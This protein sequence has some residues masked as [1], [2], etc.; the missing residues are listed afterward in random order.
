[1][2]I[3]AILC[4][5]LMFSIL[6]LHF[7][8]SVMALLLTLL[9][10]TSGAYVLAFAVVKKNTC[11]E[12]SATAMGFTNMVCI[13][14]GAPLL[15]PLIAWLLNRYSSSMGGLSL[16]NYQHALLPLCLFVFFACFMS[17]FVNDKACNELS[18]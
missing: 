15:Q 3:S 11:P 13:I 7:S 6:Y 18:G 8:L 14:L 12:I 5:I 4:L 16:E 9:G 2:F 1:M 17:L 10:V